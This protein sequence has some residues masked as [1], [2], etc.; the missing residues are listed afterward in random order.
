MKKASK[1]ITA[2]AAAV[3][4]T[5]GSAIGASACTGL[6]FGSELT[7]NGSTF[8]GRS[9][10]IGKLHNKIFEVHPAEDHEE[11]AIYKD[12]YGF[13]MPYPSHTYRYTLVK[14]S[15]LRGETMQDENGN[16]IGEAYA[17][18][19]TNE[20]GVSMSATVS[21]SY[22]RNTVGKVDPLVD[23]G[24]CEISLGTVILS[25][26]T[27]AR[28]G[29]ELLADIIDEYG[30]GECNSI[31]I[32]DK[33]EVWT[34]DTL[35]GYQYVAVKMPDDKASVN[36][37]MMIIDAAD[38]SDTENVVASPGLVSMPEEN[39]FLVTDENGNIDI[40]KTY[41]KTDCGSGQYI[42]YWQGVHYLNPDLASKVD[43]E[44]TYDEEGN[45][46]A[47]EGPFDFLIDTNKKFSTLEVLQLL[48]Y[49][50][51]GT[52][53]DAGDNG[54]AIGN[55]RQAECHVFEIRENMPEALSQLEWLALS[56]AEYSVYLPY[57]GSLMTETDEIFAPMDMKY[58]PDSFYWV[59][60]TLNDT[61][62]DNRE[63]YGAN[64][65][66]FWEGYQE[67]LIEQQAAVDEDMIKVYEYD[68]KLA[69]EKAT[70]LAKA[71][72]KEAYGYAKEMLTEL[73][74]FIE[75]GTEGEF[76]PSALTE[77]K[78]PT[79]SFDMVG[80]TG[81]P[82]EPE[83]SEPESSAPETSN[84]ESSAPESSNPESSSSSSSSSA[85]SSSSSSSIHNPSTGESTPLFAILGLATVA[86]A[87]M[88]FMKKKEQK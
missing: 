7:Q 5:L 47:P 78:G 12:K 69:E 24:I 53:Y 14:D 85:S 51:E 35:S 19:G 9:E 15:P 76:V 23:T 73:Q 42:R 41:G 60:A 50:G 43:V 81:L 61:C 37:N 26:A 49:R 28:H 72:S 82:E 39:G 83:T 16:Y 62:D 21:T 27:S 36:P 34:F 44:Y 79:Y 88:I 17:E 29:V 18:A 13:S 63:L 32:S 71:V 80:G 20:N 57:Y 2:L 75:A 3:V 55:E 67:K 30:S 46:I 40:A 58:N 31:T 74:A 77:G 59:M 65:K 1:I 25:Q 86:G 48:A 22:N 84:P 52:K 4:M 70:E 45:R 33:D 56:R 11:G 10:D 66:K 38:V 54:T 68:P 6:Y 87:A 8:M 64:V